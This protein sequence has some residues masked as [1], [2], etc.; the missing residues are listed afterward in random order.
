MLY[1]RNGRNKQVCLSR[2]VRTLIGSYMTSGLSIVHSYLANIN[3]TGPVEALLTLL[4]ISTDTRWKLALNQF[5]TPL[6]ENI[7]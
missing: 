1:N 7:N 2:D 6:I 3:K 4:V 5:F